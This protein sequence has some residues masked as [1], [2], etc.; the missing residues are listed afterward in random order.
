H[1][2]EILVCPATKAPVK[3][4]ARDKLAILNREVE[5]GGISYVDGEPVDAP[6]DDAL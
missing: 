2:L 6:L 5:K 1:L 4:L 3:M